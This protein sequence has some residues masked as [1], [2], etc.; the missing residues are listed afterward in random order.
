[1]YVGPSL[2]HIAKTCTYQ[3]PVQ[4]AI[5]K[6]HSWAKWGREKNPLALL[7]L[8][9]TAAVL[10]E[11]SGWC[12][13]HLSDIRKHNLQHRQQIML[14]KQVLC[15]SEVHTC[16][17]LPLPLP[18]GAWQFRT[19]FRTTSS[20]TGHQCIFPSSHDRLTLGLLCVLLAE[21]RCTRFGHHFDWPCWY[22]RGTLYLPSWPCS[23]HGA[24]C[25]DVWISALTFVIWHV[26]QWFRDLNL[27]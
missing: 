22:V 1:M 12:K 15:S 17:C 24:T 25:S 20:I 7:P 27:L 13:R 6:L 9:F 10:W 19:Q 11:C 23:R 16:I 8:D 5:R 3:I 4:A 18:T 21:Y 14:S 26:T 2:A